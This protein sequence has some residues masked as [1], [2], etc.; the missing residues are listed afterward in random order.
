MMCDKLSFHLTQL[1]S[2]GELRKSSV[3]DINDRGPTVSSGVTSLQGQDVLLHAVCTL[4][5]LYSV[6]SGFL[7]FLEAGICASLQMHALFQL[8]LCQREGKCTSLLLPLMLEII[9]VSDLLARLLM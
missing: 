2:A 1:K 9:T 8:Q 4:T 3:T 6:C 5:C 7:I